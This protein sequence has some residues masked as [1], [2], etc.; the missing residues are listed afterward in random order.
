M[1]CRQAATNFIKIS[2]LLNIL[3]TYDCKISRGIAKRS[4]QA[5]LEIQI[6]PVGKVYRIIRNIAKIHS[7]SKYRLKSSKT[8]LKKKRLGRLQFRLKSSQSHTIK[9]NSMVISCVTARNIRR[10]WNTKK[11]ITACCKILKIFVETVQQTFLYPSTE[12]GKIL[13]QTDC[14]RFC[15]NFNLLILLK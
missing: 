10:F 13:G 5:I 3:N 2:Q 1:S 6:F 15:I 4:T 11:W 7:I 14:S 9:I 8:N 12:S